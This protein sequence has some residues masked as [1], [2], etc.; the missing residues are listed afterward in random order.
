MDAE[1]CVELLIFMAYIQKNLPCVLGK[2]D[3]FSLYITL[4]SLHNIQRAKRT[5]PLIL[6]QSLSSVASGPRLRKLYLLLYHINC[7]LFQFLFQIYF[8]MEGE[9][10]TP[11][12]NRAFL[13]VALQ[14][15]NHLS[16]TLSNVQG[17]LFLASFYIFIFYTF[18]FLSPQHL[19]KTALPIL[20]CL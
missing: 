19:S 17:I 1:G 6:Y 13:I 11:Q 5:A 14:F 18:I 7:S 9:L 12:L 20:N 4:S 8:K 10:C 3:I 2:T 15:E 16:A